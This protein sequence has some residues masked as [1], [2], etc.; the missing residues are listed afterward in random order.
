AYP[1]LGTFFRNVGVVP[2]SREAVT[3]AL[4]AGNSVVVWPGGEVDAMRS[5]K[6]RNGVLF[7]GRRGFGK[8]AIPSG[9]P[10]VR[11][12]TV[13]GTETVFVLSEGRWLA[14]LLQLKK[15]LRA[16]NLPIVAGLPF[17]IW[18]ELLPSHFPLPAKITN[19]ILE[20]ILVRHDPK[21]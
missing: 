7:A 3:A 18:P 1:G 10:I 4:A 11:V 14:K 21:A 13:G 12:A 9:G 8:E 6:K 16:E 15:L 17:G 2:A 5:W 19:E 20:P